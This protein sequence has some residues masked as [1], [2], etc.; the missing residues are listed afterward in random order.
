MIVRDGGMPNPHF[1]NARTI[2]PTL[3]VWPYVV[4]NKEE[5]QGVSDSLEQ[6]H[7]YKYRWSYAMCFKEDIQLFLKQ[8]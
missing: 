8:G 7:I 5:R 4:I 3:K 2:G 6:P 1:Y